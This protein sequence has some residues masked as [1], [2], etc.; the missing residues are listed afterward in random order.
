MVAKVS[1]KDASSFEVEQLSRDTVRCAAVAR[2]KIRR[3]KEGQH[4]PLTDSCGALPPLAH[5]ANAATVPVNVFTLPS[6]DPVIE[7][8]VDRLIRDTQRVLK[9]REAQLTSGQ[10][11]RRRCTIRRSQRLL[12]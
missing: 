1:Q 2:E 4:E 3:P 7:N 12:G 6:L 10:Y 9:H 11:V 5:A 8:N